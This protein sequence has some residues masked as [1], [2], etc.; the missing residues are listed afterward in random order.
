MA[1]TDRYDQSEICFAW[2]YLAMAQ[3]QESQ[4]WCHQLLQ[5]LQAQLVYQ[6]LLVPLSI[7]LHD[8]ERD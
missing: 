8:H 7:R 1:I 5:F 4:S 3:R 2:L 6:T